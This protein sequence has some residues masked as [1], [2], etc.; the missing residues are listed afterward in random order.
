[1]QPA[2]RHTRHPL[3]S[4]VYTSPVRAQTSECDHQAVPV[5][6]EAHAQWCVAHLVVLEAWVPGSQLAQVK[7]AQDHVVTGSGHQPPV[8]APGNAVD[9]VAM[10]LL[11]EVRR[12]VRG[13]IHTGQKEPN[14][15]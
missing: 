5:V 3:H 4:P 2:Q 9:D 10:T 6:A 1:M 13:G 7:E 12:G 11:A 8:W 14:E 15:C